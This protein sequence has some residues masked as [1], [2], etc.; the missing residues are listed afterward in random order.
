MDDTEAHKRQGKSRIF[1]ALKEEFHQLSNEYPDFENFAA[2][3]E[4]DL[5]NAHLVSVATYYELMPDLRCLL[6]QAAAGQLDVFLALATELAAI[7][8]KESRRQRLHAN[9]QR[10]AARRA[11]SRLSLAMAGPSQPGINREK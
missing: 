3:F 7:K 11:T 8:D 5:N 2:F 9:C 4:Q 6:Q 10:P 1:F